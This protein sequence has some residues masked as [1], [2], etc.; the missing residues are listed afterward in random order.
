MAIIVNKLTIDLY[1]EADNY[2][3]SQDAQIIVEPVLIGL[4][5]GDQP[6]HYFT[7]KSES[8]FNFENRKEINE[9]FENIER[10]VYSCK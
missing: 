8:G 10:I 3:G 7:F 4:F 5:E 6:T 2:E 1:Q 9:L